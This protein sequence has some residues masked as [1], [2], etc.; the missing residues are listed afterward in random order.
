MNKKRMFFR[1]IVCLTT[2]LLI[3][4]AGGVALSSV[5]V[6]EYSGFLWAVA[7]ICLWPYLLLEKT[8]NTGNIAA[9]WFWSVNI[10]GWMLILFPLFFIKLKK[11]V[12]AKQ[13]IESCSSCYPVKKEI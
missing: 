2:S 9:I 5:L 1:G 10:E 7:S 4:L 6:K 3:T 11:P 12:S 13:D 8:L